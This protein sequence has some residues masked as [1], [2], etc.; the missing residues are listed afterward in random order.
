METIGIKTTF[1]TSGVTFEIKQNDD[2]ELF[3]S[4]SGGTLQPLLDAHS[5]TSLD[6]ATTLVDIQK[7]GRLALLAAQIK[8]TVG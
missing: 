6:L 4:L 3:V 2:G 8:T 5:L 1:A 7:L